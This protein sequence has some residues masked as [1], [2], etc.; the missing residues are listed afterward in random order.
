MK[1]S[2]TLSEQLCTLLLKEEGAY[3]THDYLKMSSPSNDEETAKDVQPSPSVSCDDQQLATYGQSESCRYDGDD[4]ADSPGL[5]KRKRPTSSGG[6]ECCGS[7]A[8][9]EADRRG[10]W[11]SLLCQ[12]AYTV[13]DHFDLSREII[14]ITMNLFDRFCANVVEKDSNN[15]EGLLA[16][17]QNEVSLAVMT[18]LQLAMKLNNYTYIH[19]SGTRSTMETIVKLG[20]GAFSLEQV[21]AKEFEILFSL[22]WQVHPPTPQLFLHCMFQEFGAESEDHSKISDVKEVQDLAIYLVEM[23]MMDYFFVAHKPSDVALASALCAFS[24][25][26]LQMTCA[27]DPSLLRLLEAHRTE[28]T[29]EC[30]ER[31]DSAYASSTGSQELIAGVAGMPQMKSPV[32]V[33]ADLQE[34]EM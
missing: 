15:A 1:A 10:G 4:M 3:A 8:S 20:R 28:G 33:A 11:R 24:I 12:W 5:K 14:S 21:E 29:I 13:V 30:Q 17:G 25:L 7:T 16:L 18:C 6:V 19:I 26:P 22:D 23:S 32:C 27:V 9:A 31:L 2:A 34:Q